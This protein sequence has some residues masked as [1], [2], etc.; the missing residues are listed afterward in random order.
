MAS[1]SIPIVL[2]APPRA[3]WLLDGRMV[4]SA[5]GTTVVLQAPAGN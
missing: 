4:I 5:G 1:Q 2:G 3:I